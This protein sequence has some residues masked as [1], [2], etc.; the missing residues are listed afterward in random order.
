MF[1]KYSFLIFSKNKN[2]FKISSYLVYILT[3]FF[4][5]FLNL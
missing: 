4:I 5:N 2:V 1:E 3:I